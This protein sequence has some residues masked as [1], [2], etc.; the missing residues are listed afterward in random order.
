MNKWKRVK[1]RKDHIC[2]ACGNK[3]HKGEAYD[4][5]KAR[6]PRYDK[7]DNQVGVEFVQIIAHPSEQHCHWPD[8]CKKGNHVE[9]FYTDNH[10]DSPEYG[11]T[12]CCCKNCATDLSNIENPVVDARKE[13]LN[14]PN[15]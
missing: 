12:F 13:A 3:I 2:E 10:P 9:V 5:L 7:N 4:L 14:Q 8:E 1:S 11:D 6:T 15:Q